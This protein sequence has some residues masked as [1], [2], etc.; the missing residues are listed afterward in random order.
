MIISHNV[1]LCNVYCIVTNHLIGMSSD[2]LKVRIARRIYN[3]I[4]FSTDH[5]KN[6][7]IVSPYDFNNACNILTTIESILLCCDGY[8]SA[9]NEGIENDQSFIIGML[10]YLP[11]SK[12]STIRVH[13]EPSFELLT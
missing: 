12:T 1:Y 10:G 9:L 11:Y 8:D 4:S 5:C 2:Y 13:N 3:E 6:K 7:T